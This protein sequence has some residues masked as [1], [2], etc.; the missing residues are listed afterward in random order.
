M[1]QR[2][3]FS[4]SAN[5]RLKT[6]MTSNAAPQPP[7]RGSYGPSRVT[8]TP[9][10]RDKDTEQHA[11]KPTHYKHHVRNKN[12]NGIIDGAGLLSECSLEEILSLAKPPHGLKSL[13]SVKISCEYYC[14]H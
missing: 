14:E 13:T 9:H 6:L 4:L 1:Q 8:T 2:V 7:G 10:Q 12:Y 11:K 5:F 3:K